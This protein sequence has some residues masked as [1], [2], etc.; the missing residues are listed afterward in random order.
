[1]IQRI[2]SAQHRNNYLILVPC[3]AHDKKFSFKGGNSRVRHILHLDSAGGNPGYML[4][5]GSTQL[6]S[7]Y[8]NTDPSRSLVIFSDL[9]PYSVPKLDICTVILLKYIKLCYH[10]DMSEL[11]DKQHKYFIA[12]KK[13]LQR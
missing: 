11:Q 5:S 7:L 6:V 12:I 8:R 1:M 3:L 2:S 13:Y 9:F 10:P 4:F